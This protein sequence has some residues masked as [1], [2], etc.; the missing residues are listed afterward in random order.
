MNNRVI[1]NREELLMQARE[2]ISSS[3]DG[4]YLHKVEMVSLVLSGVP[5]STLVNAGIGSKASITGWVKKA[6]EG[7]FETLSPKP[8]PG[9]PPRLNAAQIALLKE[10]V[11]KD[12][13]AYGYDIWE[14]KTLSAYIRREFD[15]RLEVRQCQRLLHSMGF[16]LQR[17][18]T[19]PAGKVSEEERNEFKKN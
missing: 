2:I 6:V 11:S 7:G 9:R 8:I 4:D 3:S 1:E 5:V 19:I 18:R 13:E 10:A 17:P 15:V 14:G 16:S 12:P